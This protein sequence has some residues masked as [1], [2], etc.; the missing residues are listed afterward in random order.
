MTTQETIARTRQY[1]TAI[2]AAKTEFFSTAS[3]D[4]T[5]SDAYGAASQFLTTVDSET[6]SFTATFIPVAPAPNI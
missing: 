3:P 2:E 5:V 6:E 1:I 4:G